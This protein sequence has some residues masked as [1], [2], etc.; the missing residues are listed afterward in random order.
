MKSPLPDKISAEHVQELAALGF[1]DLANRATA[2]RDELR[3]YGAP[4]A[5]ITRCDELAFKASV[6]ENDATARAA[7]SA[8]HL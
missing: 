6:G 7:Q 1:R 8:T 2:L 3:V 5:I 4:Q